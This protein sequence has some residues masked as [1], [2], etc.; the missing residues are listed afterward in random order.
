MVSSA[1]L[2]LLLSFFNKPDREQQRGE[3][4]ILMIKHP[5]PAQPFMVLGNPLVLRVAESSWDRV[6][7]LESSVTASAPHC[8]PCVCGL[9][10]S[11]AWLG[12]GASA[13]FQWRQGALRRDFE[14]RQSVCADAADSWGMRRRAASRA[15][16]RYTGAMAV[17]AHTPQRHQCGGG[18]L[19]QQ[20]CPGD[21]GL[22]GP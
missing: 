21:L 2:H 16:D 3:M 9:Q 15:A 14:T 4:L 7:R 10:K 6:M 5:A 18:R 17:R 1:I 13:I 19:S 22:V 8:S 12:S 20:T 11:A